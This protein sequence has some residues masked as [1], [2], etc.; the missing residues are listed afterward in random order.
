MGI[1]KEKLE[2][3]ETENILLKESVQRLEEELHEVRESNCHL[4][5]ELSTGKKLF[6]KQEAGLLEAKQ[7]LIT[8]ENLNSELCTTIDAL[9]TDRH[10]SMQTNEILEKKI[11][12]KSNTNTTQSQEVEVLREVNMNLV[13]ELGKLHE[14]LV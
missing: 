7:K 8:S 2:M 5:L 9:N 6:D 12:E 4:K 11:V 13:A 1:L 14:E 10:E 3:K